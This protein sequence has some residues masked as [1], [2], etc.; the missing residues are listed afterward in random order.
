MSVLGRSCFRV[1]RA[2]CFTTVIA[3][4]LHCFIGPRYR[5]YI[6]FSF[7][8]LLTYLLYECGLSIFIDESFDIDAGVIEY[9]VSRRRVR[10]QLVAQTASTRG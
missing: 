8:Y 6:N 9:Y 7:T 5:V 4:W 10:H 1:T 2:G 3:Y